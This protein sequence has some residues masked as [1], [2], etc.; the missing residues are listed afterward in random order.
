M[1][2]K[3]QALN[4][5]ALHTGTA[6]RGCSRLPNAPNASSPTGEQLSPGC[7]HQPGPLTPPQGKVCMKTNQPDPKRGAKHPPPEMGPAS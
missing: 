6:T 4:H 3:G 2:R 5:M 7:P 1:Q